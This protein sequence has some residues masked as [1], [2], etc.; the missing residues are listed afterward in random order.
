MILSRR[1]IPLVALC[2][3]FAALVA[4]PEPGFAQEGRDHSLAPGA[5]AL[6]F[7][8]LDNFQ[9]GTFEGTMLSIKRHSSAAN[10]IRL[11]VGTSLFGSDQTDS[12]TTS[13][14]PQREQSSTEVTL[15]LQYMHYPS[16][17][18][19]VNVY[20]AVGP[21]FALRRQ[22]VTDELAA[23]E[24]EQV[25]RSWSAGVEGNLGLEWFPFRSVGIHAEYGAQ[26]EFSSITSTLEFTD[27][28]LTDR[29][30][31]IDRWSFGGT[32]VTFGASVYF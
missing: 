7:R 19:D 17:G 11:G 6:Q 22:S 29:E 10:A 13:F 3:S 32:G 9:L 28:V 25:D 21:E 8:I 2:L 30:L 26:V 31:E 5:W 14:A 18:S 16:P 27:P 15:Q 12:D 20:L 4:F 1:S 23:T 24:R